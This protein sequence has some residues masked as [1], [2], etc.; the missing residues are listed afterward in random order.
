MCISQT[1]RPLTEIIFSGNE[2]AATKPSYTPS[3]RNGAASNTE[4]PEFHLQC[5]PSIA[6][7]RSSGAAGD[8]MEVVWQT[9]IIK[10]FED[11][12]HHVTLNHIEFGFTMCSLGQS[13]RGVT[14]TFCTCGVHLC[15]KTTEL[16]LPV[17]TKPFIQR[18]PDKAMLKRV[19][20]TWQ[21][22]LSTHDVL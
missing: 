11:V 17:R 22:Y 14:S 8:V 18:S 12:Y 7:F 21:L 5:R 2:A 13:V 3:F 19:H 6:A 9:M 20:T 1:F 10:F 15:Q 16:A 4:L